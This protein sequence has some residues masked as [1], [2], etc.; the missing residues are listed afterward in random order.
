MST[1]YGFYFDQGRCID[2]RTCELACK[3]TNNVEPGIKWRKVTETWD[4][5][6]PD[7]S[8]TFFSLS[9]MH[10]ENPACISACPEGAIIKRAEDGIVVVD[11]SKC[12]GCREC[13]PACPYGIPQFGKDGIMQKC[14]FC[15]GN[16]GTPAC[17]LSC[18]A[19][20]LYSGIVADLKE[21]AKQKGKS[22]KEVRVN[23]GPSIVIVT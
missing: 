7:I 22:I 14:D 15:I 8:R 23:T 4:G 9:C 19:E 21:M 1:Q 2:C 10:C 6:Y 3:S 12:N 13:L 17:T 20:A 5:T 16:G 11:N 18:P